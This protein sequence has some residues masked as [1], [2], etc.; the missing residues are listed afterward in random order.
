[1]KFQLYLE[2]AFVSSKNVKSTGND[3]NSRTKIKIKLIKILSCYK[4]T[5]QMGTCAGN[6]VVRIISYKDMSYLTSTPA[7]YN[8]LISFMLEGE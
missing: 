6:T 5:V 7:Q 2:L 8:S 1:M 3:I 4:G